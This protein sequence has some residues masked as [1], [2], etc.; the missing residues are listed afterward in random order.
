MC[1]QT[2]VIDKSVIELPQH[3]SALPQ[4]FVNMLLR[5]RKPRNAPRIFACGVD[6]VDSTLV[7]VTLDLEV[8]SVTPNGK[9]IP[10]AA[11]PYFDGWAIGIKMKDTD[12]LV[13]LTSETVIKSATSCWETTSGISVSLEV[14][15]R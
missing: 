14:V 12:E 5:S 13:V 4:E 11:F 10:E 7:V 3:I 15:N 1:K 9:M 8:L 6:P 2:R